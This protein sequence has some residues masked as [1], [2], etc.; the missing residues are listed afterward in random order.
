MPQNFIEK[1]MKKT[2]L[3]ELFHLL[4]EKQQSNKMNKETAK[5][6]SLPW[7]LLFCVVLIY[8]YEKPSIS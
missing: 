8:P 4:L 1:N 7:R 2:K 5:F 6:S 3:H